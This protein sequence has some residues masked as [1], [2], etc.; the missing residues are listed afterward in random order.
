MKR[1]IGYSVGS[2]L[3]PKSIIDFSSTIDKYEHIDSLWI[4]ESWGKEAF[5]ILGAISQVTKRIKLGTSIINIYSRTPA[6][7]AMGAISLDI[8]S[9]K[10]MIIGL[11]ASTAAIIENL[12]GV[13]YSDPLIRMKE[14]IQSLRLLIKSDGNTNYNGKIVKIKN[15][16][17]LE[18]S[19]LEIPIH[20]AAVNKK[21]IR[22]GLDYADGLLFYLRP[23][24]EIKNLLHEIKNKLKFNVSLVLITSVSN[25]EPQKAKE[26]AAKTLA[27]Y[28]SVGKVYYDFLSKTEFK[29]EVENIYKEYHNH[30]LERSIEN[31]STKM[32]DDLVVYGSVNDCNNQIKRFMNTGIDLPILQMNPVNDKNGELNYKDFLEL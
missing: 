2:L 29:T 15:F 23:I 31:I 22:I 16:K 8:L 11:G 10:R 20:I 21:M 27:F 9:N 4:P 25:S 5:S 14:Y 12:H 18:K 28:I 32:L 3:K 6:T 13:E 7:I 19:R 17:I 1:K 30:G 26:R 24:N